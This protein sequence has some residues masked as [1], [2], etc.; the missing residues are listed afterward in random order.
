MHWASVGAG[1]AAVIGAAVVLRWL[2]GRPAAAVPPRK[3]PARDGG[4]GKIDV[5]RAT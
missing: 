4:P 5:V 3:E 2:P 1:L